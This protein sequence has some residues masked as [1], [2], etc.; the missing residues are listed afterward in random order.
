[1]SKIPGISRRHCLASALG[2]EIE[3]ITIMVWESL[4]ALKA[5]AGPNYE[6]A[7]IPE[8]R[9]EYLS[10]YDKQSAHYEIRSLQGLGRTRRMR[11]EIPAAVFMPSALH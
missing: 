1:M 7:I 10:R 9:L 6:A 8:D 11:T 4:E 5:V 3:F 2:D